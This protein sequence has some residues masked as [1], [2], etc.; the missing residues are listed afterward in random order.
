M[1]MFCRSLF[2]L[3][4][5]F[6][7]PLGCLFFLDVRILINPLVSSNSV[8]G[9]WKFKEKVKDRF[10]KMEEQ[11]LSL[12]STV[13]TLTAEVKKTYKAQLR[14]ADFRSP[15]HSREPNNDRYRQ[16]NYDK[17]INL[18]GYSRNK[19][20]RSLSS[21]EYCH[22]REYGHFRRDFPNGNNL[23]GNHNRSNVQ[24]RRKF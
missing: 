12:M 13:T 10:C 9:V 3:L 21:D 19:E 16:E 17:Y 2:A 6:F 5:L 8:S 7:W 4:Y 14:S 11:M 20:I 1:C 23:R 15:K 24:C 22:C 18:R